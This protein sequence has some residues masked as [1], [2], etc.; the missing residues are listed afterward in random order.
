MPSVASRFT[1]FVLP[2]ILQQ[3]V[4]AGDP[5]EAGTTLPTLHE[6]QRHEWVLQESEPLAAGA[7]LGSRLAILPP[8]GL[9][10]A[11]LW[12]GA[13][14]QGATQTCEFDETEGYWWHCFADEPFDEPHTLAVAADDEQIVFSA[15]GEDDAAVIVD[16]LTFE[17]LVTG[18]TGTVT[19]LAKSGADLVVG[20]AGHSANAGRLRFFRRVGGVWQPPQTIVGP[21]G[22]RLGAS[23][24]IRGDVV[25]AG[26]PGEGDCGAVHV[27]GDLGSWSELQVVDCPSA[28]Q[29]DA[30]FGAAVALALGTLAVGAPALD[31][32]VAGGDNVVDV[33]GVYTFRSSLLLFE[34][35]TLLRPADNAAGDRF[36][37]TVSLTPI[38]ALGLALVAGAPGEAG[39]DIFDLDSGAVHLFLDWGSWQHTVRLQDSLAGS[40]DR[41][42]SALAVGHRTIAAGAPGAEANSTTDQ[43]VVLT[44][45]DR[46]PLFYDGFQS[47][48]TDGWA[49]ATN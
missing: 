34:L 40:N 29:V 24:A 1:S 32:L 9:F 2:L 47:G 35:E 11:R 46:L 33:G 12:M 5:V 43:G 41:M 22:S 21:P 7:A 26:A 31:R 49:A 27:Y 19:A 39:P 45:D 28:V 10:D 17:P 42:G 30:E 18:L 3:T 48:G 44:F 6:N 15:E 36:G 25:A 23:L 14:S 38:G 8:V 4:A 37:A 20:D 16:H 13:P